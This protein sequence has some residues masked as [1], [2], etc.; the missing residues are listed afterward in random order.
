MEDIIQSKVEDRLLLM[1]QLGI[2]LKRSGHSRRI[3]PLEQIMYC[4]LMSQNPRRFKAIRE[5]KRTK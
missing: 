3:E 2:E 1:S 4:L 5:C